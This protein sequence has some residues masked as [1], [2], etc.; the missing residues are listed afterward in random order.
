MNA[1]NDEGSNFES[2]SLKNSTVENP[3]Y[4]LLGDSCDPDVNFLHVNFENLNIPYLFQ[5]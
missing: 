1:N 3:N 4:I 5:E 2:K